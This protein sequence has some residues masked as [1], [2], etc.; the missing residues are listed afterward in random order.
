MNLLNKII[1]K[2]L[3]EKLNQ[4][5]LTHNNKFSKISLKSICSEIDQTIIRYVKENKN[6]NKEYDNNFYSINKLLKQLKFE[7]EKKEELFPYYWRN[8]GKIFINCFDEIT[9]DKLMSCLGGV[10]VKK[11]IR[12]MN[13][14]KNGT[15]LNSLADL[16]INQKFNFKVQIP[17][18]NE[19]SLIL[20]CDPLIYTSKDIIYSN[21]KGEFNKNI[22]FEVNLTTNLLKNKNEIKINLFENN[23]LNENKI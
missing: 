8:R 4:Q 6:N 10:G 18:D 22:Q 19:N 17:G 1:N 15:I 9:I 14:I 21:N 11:G 23:I 7:N 3:N 2:I 13:V 16:K 12:I 20:D 5:L